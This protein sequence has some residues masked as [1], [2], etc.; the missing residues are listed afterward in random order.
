[1]EGINGYV[2]PLIDGERNMHLVIN[3][4]PSATQQTGIY[5]ARWV[6]GEWSQVVP[7]DAQSRAAG[8][9]HYTD[10]AVRL[11]NE[12]HVVYNDI[13]MAEIYYLRG[14]VPSVAAKTAIEPS[15]VATPTSQ[16]TL[17]PTAT[18]P[19]LENQPTPV[20][21]REPLLEQADPVGMTSSSREVLVPAIGVPVLLVLL[22]YG[23]T[24]IRAKR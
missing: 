5:Y 15:A 21:T 20:K 3:M 9:A 12:L 2:I 4:R 19:V 13:G 23:W 1:M 7:V 24:Q 22:V 6:G 17:M 18:T 16:A 11:G 14:I 8:S 10:A